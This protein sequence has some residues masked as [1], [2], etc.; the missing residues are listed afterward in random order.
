MISKTLLVLL[1]A[2]LTAD[3]L[4]ADPSVYDYEEID[5]L[6]EQSTI[7]NES[8]EL[9]D[10]HPSKVLLN[11]RNDFKLSNANRF[12]FKS[13]SDNL[14]A[15]VHKK[16]SQAFR[17]YTRFQTDQIKLGLGSYR[18]SF[19]LGNT[20]KKARNTGFI[21]RA[22][23][24]SQLDLKGIFLS[25]KM[26]F[27]EISLFYSRTNL[28]TINVVEDSWKLVYYDGEK[29]ELEQ[30][31]VISKV[32]FEDFKI[33]FL[34]S[35]YKTEKSLEQ[36][37]WDKESILWATFVEYKKE[38]Y[39]LQYEGS[40]YKKDIGHFLKTEFCLE[41]FST[42][43]T[44]QE[45]PSHSLNWINTG[46]TN[47]YNANTT[48][49]SGHCSFPLNSIDFT[50]GSELKLN[51]KIK[52]WRSCSYLK[53]NPSKEI[54]YQIIQD[55]YKDSKAIIQEKY[56]QKISYKAF[57]FSS[58]E[59]KVSYSVNNKKNSGIANM[60]QV[61]YN[62]R[63]NVGLVRVNLKVLDNYKNEEMVQDIDDNIIATFYD[64]SE[65][66]LLSLHY[67]SK[68][69]HNFILGGSLIQSLYNS[70][71]NTLKIELSFLL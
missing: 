19:G 25:Y 16:E 14:T 18:P 46:I 61:D 40:H 27:S 12:I 31:G 34:T 9:K 7:E 55:K 48:I 56:T 62:L 5:E 37:A 10:W 39:S 70:K 23:S 2:L 69:K 45:I 58:S 17:L 21:N 15:I 22:L 28:N 59:L 60:Y 63:S 53:I 24:T 29:C 11:I 6:I 49:Y 64:Y 65:D 54:S 20:Y 67:N 50:L 51:K 36:F 38:N 71:I 66:V 44:Y 26:L 41:D 35:L 68:K 3:N 30:Y 57:T 32:K 4:I 1:I 33:N 13:D 42:T 47:L 43:W 8:Q 52:Q